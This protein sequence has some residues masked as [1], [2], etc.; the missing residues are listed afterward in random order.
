[1]LIETPSAP[2]LTRCYPRSFTFYVGNPFPSF[3]VNKLRRASDKGTVRAFRDADRFTTL[4]I[5]RWPGALRRRRPEV[6]SVIENRP[7]L[8]RFP[9]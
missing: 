7:D 3:V 1:M 4:E 9:Q 5:V 6:R 8:I 2:A